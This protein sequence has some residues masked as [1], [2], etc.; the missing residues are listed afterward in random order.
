MKNCIQKVLIR[1]LKPL[2]LGAVGFVALSTHSMAAMLKV[3]DEYGGGKVAY[4]F[5]PG[6]NDYAKTADQAV[7]VAKADVSASLYWSDTRTSTDK[8]EGIGYYDGNLPRRVR[9][10][11]L[12]KWTPIFGQQARVV[13]S[14]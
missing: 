11:R 3:G 12:V 10:D 14:K 6:D 5:Q 13:I 2:L 4:I 7:I 8:L 1:L 9:Q